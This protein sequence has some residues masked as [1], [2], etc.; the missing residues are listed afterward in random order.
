MKITLIDYTGYGMP[1]PARFAAA[2]LI[3][4]KNTRVEMTSSTILDIMRLP[5]DK[6]QEELRYIANTIPGSWEMVDFSFFVSEASRGFT[7]QLVRTRTA[8]YAQQTMQVLDVSGFTYYEGESL[9]AD[10]DHLVAYR[11]CMA[12]IDRVYRQ[13]IEKGVA[14]QDAR[15][16]LPTAIHTN[17]VAKMNLRT[18]VDLFRSRCGPRN[19]DETAVV[20]RMMRDEIIKVHPWASLF[21]RSDADDAADQL[22]SLI[23][24]HIGDK[25]VC[26]TMLK[27]VDRMRRRA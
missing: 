9:Y 19:A 1:D 27:M 25:G 22:D 26:N 15:G 5:D 14:I 12:E 4:C 24:D 2:K 18:F 20:V 21:L 10:Q 23:S 3:F 7:H 8:S 17:I 16:L 6:I 11:D 13:L